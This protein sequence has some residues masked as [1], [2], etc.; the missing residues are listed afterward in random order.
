MRKVEIRRR[1]AEFV[2][3]GRGGKPIESRPM[4]H[5]RLVGFVPGYAVVRHKGMMPFVVTRKEWDSLPVAT[6]AEE[7]ETER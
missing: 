6:R 1:P 3:F 5:V 4:A 2:T 7:A